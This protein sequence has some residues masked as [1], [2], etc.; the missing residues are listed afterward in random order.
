ML[1]PAYQQANNGD[2]SLI[3]ELQEVM[4]SPYEEQSKEIELKYYKEKPLELFDV[5]GVSY[6]SC[7]S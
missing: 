2:Y 6:V 1:V 3:Y 4:N 7:S 5:A